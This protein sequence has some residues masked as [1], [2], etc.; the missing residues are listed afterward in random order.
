MKRTSQVEHAWH[1]ENIQALLT[2]RVITSFAAGAVLSH[3]SSRTCDLVLLST[4]PSGRSTCNSVHSER[5][6]EMKCIVMSASARLRWHH[7]FN[8][9]IV[10][11]FLHNV[12]TVNN[13]C[14]L[15]RCC[16]PWHLCASASFECI[17][18]SKPRR[19]SLL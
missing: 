14:F 16:T 5:K 18:G 9:S 8:G 12:L 17:H 13:G 3:V 4:T 15:W 6:E 11:S 10:V 19:C 2:K 7:A 1:Q